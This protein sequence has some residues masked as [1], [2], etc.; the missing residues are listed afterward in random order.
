MRRP[1]AFFLLTGALLLGGCI[2]P[3]ELQAV[4][5]SSPKPSQGVIWLRDYPAEVHFD[6]S[7]STGEIVSYRWTVLDEEGEGLSSGTGEEFTYQFDYGRYLVR[8]EVTGFDLKTAEAQ[9]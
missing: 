5:D 8:L 1:V 6:A 2:G 4:I 9:V 7:K 3:T